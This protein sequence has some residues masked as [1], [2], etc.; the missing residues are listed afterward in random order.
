MENP[1]AWQQVEA[2]HYEL[3]GYLCLGREGGGGDKELGARFIQI[4]GHQLIPGLIN[5]G[6][7]VYPLQVGT[8]VSSG[9]EG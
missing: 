5:P 8:H 1:A 6:V 9:L 2:A 7:R 4:T 3:L